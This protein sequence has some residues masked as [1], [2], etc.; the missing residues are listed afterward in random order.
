M[1]TVDE[2]GKTGYYRHCSPIKTAAGGVSISPAAI[3]MFDQLGTVRGSARPLLNMSRSHERAPVF[4]HT[5]FEKTRIQLARVSAPARRQLPHTV[6]P[7]NPDGMSSGTG[8]QN[9]DP[10]TFSHVEIR[11]REEPGGV[12]DGFGPD[13]SLCVL[14]EEGF[15][16][17]TPST[18]TTQSGRPLPRAGRPQGLRVDGPGRPEVFWQ[19]T[20]PQ[21]RLVAPGSSL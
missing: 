2:A 15:E 10:C 11:A 12:A 9:T 5:A 8:H 18:R 19:G 20:R 3:V 7:P 4:R 21:M 14:S 13:A 1:I 16:S 6:G 17:A